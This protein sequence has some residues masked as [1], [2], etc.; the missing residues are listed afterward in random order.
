MINIIKQGCKQEPIVY[1]KKCRSCG[2]EFTFNEC[3]C[4][5]DVDL[6]QFIKCPC[7]KHTTTRGLKR[8]YKERKHGRKRI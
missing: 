7:C 8:K 6:N 3:D 5:Y 4:N 2:C 1:Y